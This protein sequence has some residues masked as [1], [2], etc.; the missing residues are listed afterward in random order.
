MKCFA[1]TTLAALGMLLGTLPVARADDDNTLIPGEFNISTFSV[2]GSKTLAVNDI[3]NRGVIVGDYSISSGAIKGFVRSANGQLTTLVEPMDMGGQTAGFTAAFGINDE[4]SVVGEFFNTAKSAYEGFFY[5][6][7]KFT[8][9]IYPA[10]PTAIS[11][12]NDIG[13]FCGFYGNPSTGYLN[14]A[15]QIATFMVNGSTNTYVDGMNNFDFVAGEYIDSAG[16]S[17]GFVRDPEG[18]ISTVDVPGAS[19][20]LYVGINDLGWISG[21]FA[22]NKGHFHGFI[23]VPNRRSWKFFQIDVPGA[24]ATYGGGLNDFGTV[25]GHYTP[26]SGGTDRG[27]I[28]SPQSGEDE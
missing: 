20:T 3:N 26:S 24:M 8:N 19:G 17:H 1:I 25:V 23:G 28:A 22:D 13:D 15:G 18:N 7:G 10:L 14:H 11:G 6:N 27:Y 16:T 9:Y 2:P 12:I 21:H 5:R 4:G